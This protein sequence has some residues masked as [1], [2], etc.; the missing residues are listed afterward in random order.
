MPAHARELK[1][2]HEV[3]DPQH[4][5]LVRLRAQFPL[6]TTCVTT[7][8]AD[9]LHSHSLCIYIYTRRTLCGPIHRAITRASDCACMCLC[10]IHL[11]SRGVCV[12]R[13]AC[14]SLYGA[15]CAVSRTTSFIASFDKARQTFIHVPCSCARFFS[16]FGGNANSQLRV[17]ANVLLQNGPSGKM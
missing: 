17:R 12:S 15:P 7:L 8:R 11:A 16:G 14:V 6:S 9:N 13:H 5:Y 1:P 4:S 10:H 2:P 3:P